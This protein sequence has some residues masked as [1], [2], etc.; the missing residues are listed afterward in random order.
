M[1]TNNT[2]DLS[3]ISAKEV[4]E[5]KCL[6]AEPPESNGEE[7]SKWVGSVVAKEVRPLL[8]LALSY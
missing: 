4:E 5:L 1:L 3:R 6:L 8:E 2:N 7:Y